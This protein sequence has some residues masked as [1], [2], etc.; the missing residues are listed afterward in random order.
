MGCHGLSIEGRICQP[1][2]GHEQNDKKRDISQNHFRPRILAKVRVS[3]AD[4]AANNNP[5]VIKNEKKAKVAKL[6]NPRHDRPDGDCGL[7]GA[8][9]F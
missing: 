1:K 3:T 7:N 9:E 6:K 2:S 8:S 5:I 4:I